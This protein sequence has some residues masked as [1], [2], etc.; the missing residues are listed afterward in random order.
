M[1]YRAFLNTTSVIN[2]KN[3]GVLS[4]C[5]QHISNHTCH[6]GLGDDPRFEFYMKIL[7]IYIIVNDEALNLEGPY[8]PTN[9]DLPK[10]ITKA[11]PSESA[12]TK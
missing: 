9:Q 10:R 8:S 12:A 2:P 5:S 1:D 3:P 11:T 6:F 7:Y 4:A